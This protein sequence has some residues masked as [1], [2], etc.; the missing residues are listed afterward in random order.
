M[1]ILTRFEK[2]PHYTETSR[3][4]RKDDEATPYLNDNEAY[5]NRANLFTS[6]REAMLNIREFVKKAGSDKKTKRSFVNDW[7]LAM[8]TMGAGSKEYKRFKRLP[9]KYRDFANLV[10][11]AQTKE[12]LEEVVDPNKNWGA[13]MYER[14][15]D[16]FN[17]IIR[18]AKP[19][20]SESVEPLGGVIEPSNEQKKFLRSIE[21]LER[22]AEIYR[23]LNANKDDIIIAKEKGFSTQNSPSGRYPF[24]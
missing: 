19:I 7:N 6:T 24:N 10:E 9:P 1:S 8:D 13:T 16:T 22:A 4:F 11:E 21:V 18:A 17:I 3:R 15:P 14:L 23:I 2:P 20:Y 12:E 5:Q